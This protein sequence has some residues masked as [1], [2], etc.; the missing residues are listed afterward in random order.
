M[1]RIEIVHTFVARYAEVGLHSG[2]ASLSFENRYAA[3]FS[4]SE[5]PGDVASGFA[6]SRIQSRMPSGLV[7][8]DTRN[9]ATS[10]YQSSPRDN[11]SPFG[12]RLGA[13]DQWHP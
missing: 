9:V 13:T 10:L 11:A 6:K 1:G 7:V 2:K 8:I 5:I 12:G 3:R 4:L